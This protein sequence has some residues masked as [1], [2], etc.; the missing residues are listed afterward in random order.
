MDART[1]RAVA[2][3]DPGSSK[4]TV[5]LGALDPQGGADV[6]DPYLLSAEDAALV[7]EKIDRSVEALAEALDPTTT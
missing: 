6:P 5:R 4:R 3:F 7:L 2:A 1:Q